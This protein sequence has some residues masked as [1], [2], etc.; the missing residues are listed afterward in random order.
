MHIGARQYAILAAGYD[1]F[2]Y[3]QPDWGKKLQIFELDLPALARDKLARVGNCGWEKPEN[4]HLIEADLAGSA[5]KTK[6]SDHPAFYRDAITFCSMLGF[7]YYVNK[8]TFSSVL[9][10]LAHILPKG[11][12]L[13]FDYH[14]DKA[15]TDM[16]GEGTKKQVMLAKEASSEMQSNYGFLEMELLLTEHSFLAYEHLQPDDITQ[17]YFSRYNKANPLHPMKASDNTNYCLAVKG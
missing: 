12:S 2:P 6:L 4:L 1:T 9:R 15:A 10:H 14:D 11:S 5:W 16:A 17:N 3:R 8:E 13:V 7:S